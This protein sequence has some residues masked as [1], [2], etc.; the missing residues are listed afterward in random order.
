MITVTRA[1]DINEMD[2]LSIIVHKVSKTVLTS[3]LSI[4]IFADMLPRHEEAEEGPQ[5]S[6]PRE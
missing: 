6:A 1:Y 5:K 3:G 4:D 2:R